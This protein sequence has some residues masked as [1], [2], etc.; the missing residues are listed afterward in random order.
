MKPKTLRLD[1]LIENPD[2]P[3]T[4]TDADF[5]LLVESLRKLPQTLAANKIAYVTDYVATSGTD[6]RGQRVVIAGNKRLR[7][8]KRLAHDH[9]TSLDG[10]IVFGPSAPAEWFFDLTPL[11]EDARRQW[12]VKSNVQSGEWDAEKLL[13]LYDEE[14][15]ADLMGADAL[16]KIL[17]ELGDASQETIVRF[18]DDGT[19][20]MKKDENLVT[21]DGI[22]VPATSEEL[23]M[24]KNKYYKYVNDNQVGYGFIRHLLGEGAKND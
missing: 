16:G 1:A 10:Q 5:D 2:N 8:L 21:F 17:K 3:Q 18:D 15:L 23:E 20:K 6:H 24:L 22:K 14:Q 7:A 9:A 13:A 4:V 12:L 11:G 19:G